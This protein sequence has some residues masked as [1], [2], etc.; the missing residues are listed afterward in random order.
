MVCA[1][2][3]V[4]WGA[5]GALVAGAV[6]GAACDDDATVDAVDD[7]AFVATGAVVAGT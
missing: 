4:P 7:D 6:V 1:C 5:A 3:N 2:L